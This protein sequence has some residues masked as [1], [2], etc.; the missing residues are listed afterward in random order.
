MAEHR[1]VTDVPLLW[2]AVCRSFDTWSG[3]PHRLLLAAGTARTLE[4][5]RSGDF[6]GRDSLLSHLSDLA[7][8]TDAQVTALL[9]GRREHYR[10]VLR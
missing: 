4:H 9:A 3:V 8:T 10:R 6:P 2:Q 5:V 1:D 7:G